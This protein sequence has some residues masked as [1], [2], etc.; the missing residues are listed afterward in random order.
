MC[1]MARCGRCRIVLAKQDE[2]EA[3]YSSESKEWATLKRYLLAMEYK[4]QACNW[5]FAVLS[6]W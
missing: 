2:S 3:S 4:F 6:G 1:G 5:V